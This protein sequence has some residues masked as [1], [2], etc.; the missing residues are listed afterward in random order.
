MRIKQIL[1]KTAVPLHYSLCFRPSL[2]TQIFAGS[3][4]ISLNIVTKTN[5]ITAN[6]LDLKII[7]ASL[8]TNQKI[9]SIDVNKEAQTVKFLFEGD[10]QEGLVDLL[11]EFEGCHNDLMA[12][13]Y[14]S[15]YTIDGK[16]KYLLAT[17][18]QAS[19]ARR[20]FPCWD[21]PNLKATFDV[22][23]IVPKDSVALS[24]MDIVK[25]IEQDDNLK[26]VIFEKTPIMSTYLLAFVVGDFEYVEAIANPQAPTGAKPV[27]LRTYTLRGQKELGRFSLD[28]GVKV[29]EF[30]SQY[31][32][33]AYPLTKLDQVAIPDFNAGGIELF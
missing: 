25:E 11:V 2:T 30:Y 28:F 21:E 12:G 15:C 3:C 27:R 4:Q 31:F 32:D 29:L 16:K 33:I 10:I 9:L 26:K 13:F 19:D 8:S 17:Q 20:A 6:A 5:Y 7:K 14:R 23:M 22:S 1:P 18:F 24:N